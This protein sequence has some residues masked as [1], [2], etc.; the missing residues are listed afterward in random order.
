MAY[1][2]KPNTGALF[3]NV[4]K[5]NDSH[6]D[7]RGPLH[8]E[9]PECRHQFEREQSA[10]LKVSKSDT[11]YMSMSL[12]EPFKKDERKPAPKPAPKPA[13]QD[14]PFSDDIPFAWA[15]AIPVAG[16]VL[17]GMYANDLLQMWA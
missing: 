10:W 14:E 8:I 3:K 12:K 11:K 13:A 15:F 1:E 16:L 7:Y 4:R 6:P 2:N 17:G 9:C 5:E